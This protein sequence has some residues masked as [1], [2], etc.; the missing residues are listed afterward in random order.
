MGHDEGISAVYDN[1]DQVHEEDFV[2]AYS[3]LEP[4]VSLDY[5]EATAQMDKEKTGKEMLKIIAELQRK[6]S[7]LEAQQVASAAQGHA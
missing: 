2:K 6:V 3:T 5:N 7:V 4:F 1:R